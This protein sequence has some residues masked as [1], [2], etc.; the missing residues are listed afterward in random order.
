MDPNLPLGDL[1][2]YRMDRLLGA[3]G[4]GEVYLAHDLVLQRDVAIKFLSV[5]DADPAKLKHRLLQ[6]AKSVAA[7]DHPGICI[8]YDVGVDQSG[9]SFMVMQYVEGE[10]LAARIKRGPLPVRDALRICAQMAEALATAHRRGIVHRDLKPQNVMITSAG[11]PKLLDFGIAKVLPAPD[12]TTVSASTNATRSGDPGTPPY[13]SPEQVQQRPLDGRSDLFSLG[14]ILYECLT[15][16]RAFE[17]TQFVEILAQILHAHP[18]APSAFRGE[19]DDRHDEILRRLLA[20]EPED[21]FQS[22]DEL[23]GALRVLRTDTWS[24]GNEAPIPRRWAERSSVR[25]AAIGIAVMAMMGVAGFMGW[26]GMRPKLPEA[27]PEA[28]KYF[29]LGT[30]ALRE[31]ASHKAESALTEAISLFPSYALAYARRAEAHADMEDTRAATSDLLNVSKLVPD[32]GRLDLDDRLRIEAI[33]SLVLVD[34][35]RAVA[36]Y[37]QLAARWPQDVGVWIDLGR[38]QEAA[39]QLADARDTY[40]KATTVDRQSAAAFLHLGV[41]E[42]VLG[43]REES[44]Q[45]LSEAERL[46]RAAGNTEGQT[47]VLIRRGAVFESRG[48]LRPAREALDRALAAARAM[49][50]PFQEIRAQMLLGIVTANSGDFTA[51][52][53]LA[54]QAVQSALEKGLE[55]RAADGLINIAAAIQGSR[56]DEAEALLRKAIDLAQSRG[57]QRTWARG[58]SQMASLDLDRGRPEQALTT[59]APALTFFETHKYRSLQVTALLIAARAHAQLEEVKKARELASRGLQEAEVTRKDNDLA[60]ANN[61]LGIVATTVGSLPEALAF[62]ARAAEIIRRQ[63]NVTGLTFSLTNQAELLLRLGRRTAANALLAE[64]EDGIRKGLQAFQRRRRHMM[65]LHALAASIDRDYG[66]AIEWSRQIESDPQGTD[67]PAI[68]GPIIGS[69]AAAMLRVPDSQKSEQLPADTPSGLK[70]ERLYWAASAALARGKYQESFEAAAAAADDAARIGNSE[71]EWR[72]AAVSSIAAAGLKRRDVA[73]QFR[74]R[75]AEALGRLRASWKEDCRDYDNRADLT[76]LRAASG[77]NR[78][79]P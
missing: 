14:C 60:L 7:L 30:D 48:E 1:A 50:N 10:T 56:N 64:V 39:A 24:T 73:E 68:L 51:A 9:R 19:L 5:A 25:R 29:D 16:R 28:V 11:S 31:G 8:V 17:G 53:Q 38:A 35:D 2:R 55:S 63:Q 18:P 67:S 49:E 26:R 72:A 79:G 3:G 40:I 57:A 59:V 33:R 13:M 43:H 42:S 71:L 78:E 77:I 46:Y 12:L 45:S 23:V 65:F 34:A 70:R 47:E 52:E 15:G 37:R 75:A 54:S 36:T 69:V 61:I 27:P 66:K 4:M 22:A 21:R 76:A 62:R 58:V 41:V 44:L 32:I 6:E 74:K 20:K